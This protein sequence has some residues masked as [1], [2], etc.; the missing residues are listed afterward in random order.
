MP[1]L[2]LYFSLQPVSATTTSFAVYFIPFM[3]LNLY[4]LYAASGQ[5]VTFRAISFN[6]S[7]W[8]LQLSA[9]WSVITRQKQSFTVT[10]KKAQKGSFVSLAYPHIAYTILAIIGSVY[11]VWRDGAT[12]AIIT[13]IAWALFNVGLFWPFMK[14]AINPTVSHRSRPAAESPSVALIHEE[15]AR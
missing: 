15:V 10:A 8:V 13:N 1:L 14:A 7:S 5:S 6:Q 9:L 11:A 4:T 2:F 3:L 12:P